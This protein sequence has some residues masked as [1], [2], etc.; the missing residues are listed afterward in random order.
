MSFLTKIELLNNSSLY[1]DELKVKQL[2]TICKCL[3]GD[4]PDPETLFLNLDRI[5][6]SLIECDLKKINFIDYFIILINLRCSSVGS[7]ISLQLT[8]NTTGEINLSEVEKIL[9]E[10]N[11]KQLLTPSVFEGIE[12]TYKLPTINDL[13]TINKDKSE[14][15]YSYFLNTLK[16][17]DNLLTFTDPKEA[18]LIF[19][20]IPPK[21]SG[22]VINKIKSII[23]S[24]N[25]LDLLS[26][27]PHFKDMKLYFN[28][29]IKNLCIFT[30]LLFGDQL[31][32]IYE[33]IF[34]LCKAGNFT[35]EYIE[36]CTPG[37]YILFVK[38]LQ[39]LNKSNT[40]QPSSNNSNF[41]GEP[42]DSYDSINPYES[43]D[44]PPI[45]S[46]FN[47]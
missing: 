13:I 21:I 46:E 29:N 3:L 35:P 1:I 47:G 20:K 27:S 10:F 24:F 18:N 40:Q 38:K 9:K 42:L 8:E 11:F 43:G 26:Y 12:I 28:F 7:R 30:K 39:E 33:N 37:E 25:E 17:K 32:S 2:K 34:G 16:I 6:S 19:N 22:A 5:I 45:T 36:N 23:Q 44:L 4:D 15:F 31:L 41:E 14:E